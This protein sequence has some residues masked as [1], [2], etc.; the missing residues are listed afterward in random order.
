MLR[1]A[2]RARFT[3]GAS[4]ALAGC[5]AAILTRAPHLWDASL[6]DVDVY[7]TMGQQWSNRSR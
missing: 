2:D 7:L 6:F 4:V 5:L 3:G 1:L